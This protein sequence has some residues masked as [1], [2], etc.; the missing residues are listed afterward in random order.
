MATLNIAMPDDLH[1]F[2][3]AQAAKQGFADVGAYVQ[4][5]FR[6]MQRGAA[7]LERVDALL[8]EG[9]DSQPDRVMTPETLES[10]RR[11]VAARR[12][13]REEQGHGAGAAGRR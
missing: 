7:A 1:G 8:V 9:L 4:A 3:E 6:G 5:V 13:A 2:I 11:E 12:R 10:V